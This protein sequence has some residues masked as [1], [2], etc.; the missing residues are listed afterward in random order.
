MIAFPNCK[1][2]IGL[3]ILRKRPDNYHDIETIFYPVPLCDVL[4]ILP[5]KKTEIS[6]SNT[7]ISVADDAGNLCLKA[8]QLLKNDFPN[9]PAV[10]IYLHKVIPVGAG[11]GGGSSNAIATL[12]LLNK[13]FSLE[14]PAEKLSL[15]ALML[16][17]DCP[18]FLLNK[19][20][21]AKGRGE[22]LE[23]LGSRLTGYHVVIVFPG[24]HCNTAK[25]FS[26]IKPHTPNESL[27]TSY[28]K[29]I[30]VWSNIISNDFEKSVFIE[31][32]SIQKIKDQLYSSGADY[33]SLSG[34]GSSVYG[35][36]KSAVP[37]L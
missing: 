4:E 25:A 23:P 11:L 8:Y 18:F 36:F 3:H 30:N 12:Q 20:A 22:M 15:Y 32:S 5:S 10:S 9:L 37:V 17:S 24:I 6:F 21:L 2:N 29:P 27:P 34:S 7:G 33:A 19:P 16:G 26:S 31:H 28:N 13:I 1:I 14:I 35:L